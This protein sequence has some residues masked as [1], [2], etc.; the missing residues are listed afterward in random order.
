MANASHAPAVAASVQPPPAPGV[1]ANPGQAPDVYGS[2]LKQ[3]AD[4]LNGAP[5]P[6]TQAAITQSREAVAQYAKAAQ[7][8]AAAVAAKNGSIG[9]GTANTM[10][11]AVRGDVLGELANSEL[12]NAQLVSNEKQAFID[13]AMQ[14]GQFAQNRA[15]NN[16]QFAATMEQRK[17]EFDKN[18]GATEAA[19]YRNQLERMALDNP[20][21]ASKL[22]NY[23]LE[24]KSG[25]VG[26]FTSQEKAEIQKYVADKKG[27]QDKL[28]EVMN[29]IIGAIP[30]Q[31]EAGNKVTADA[32]KKAEEQTQLD[33]Y[34]K[35]LN[36]LPAGGYLT[37]DEFKALE[38]S[39]G[40]KRYSA[41]NLPTD[42]QGYQ[43][44]VAST[45][46]GIISVDGVQY[47]IGAFS[48]PRTGAG[49]FSNQER[50]TDVIELIA[51]NGTKKYAYDGKIADTPPKTVSNDIT[52]WG[53]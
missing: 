32:T 30:G 36:T 6:G 48:Q 37:E 20:V 3:L 39:G 15:D 50:H 17:A 10:A 41:Q 4:G 7:N 24:G 27:Q 46:H 28:T 47:R 29:S 12:N 22:T 14:A 19:N 25:A 52:P 16:A 35:K 13:K 49:T 34:T 45:P 18:F 38:A 8:R 40:V 33:G 43:A 1:P 21:L 42:T 5:T 2:V 51:P 53:F 31:I 23:L 9:Q 11:N 44:L 26:G